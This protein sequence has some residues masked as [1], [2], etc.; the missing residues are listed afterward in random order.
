MV[1]KLRSNGVTFEEYD[2]PAGA[3]VT[4]AI[5]DFGGVKAA[6]LIRGAGVFTPVHSLTGPA[7]Q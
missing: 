4:D 5:M 6:F 1:A 3:S 7:V 2:S